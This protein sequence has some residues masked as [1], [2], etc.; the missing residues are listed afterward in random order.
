MEVRNLATPEELE[1]AAREVSMARKKWG[2]SPVQVYMKGDELDLLND[3][4][5]K[6]DISVSAVLEACVLIYVQART[7]CAIE[8]KP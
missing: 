3:V 7:I 1:L 2:K 6:S 5:A 4:A 8:I